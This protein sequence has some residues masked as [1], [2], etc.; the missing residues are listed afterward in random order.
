[1]ILALAWVSNRSDIYHRMTDLGQVVLWSID[2]Y[3]VSGS[4]YDNADS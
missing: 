4:A 2:G 3:L 1:M